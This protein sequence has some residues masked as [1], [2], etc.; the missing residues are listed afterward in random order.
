MEEQERKALCVAVIDKALDDAREF[1]GVT[2]ELHLYVKYDR[3]PE[4]TGPEGAAAGIGINL[5]YLRMEI[6]FDLTKDDRPK[7]WWSYAAHEIAHTVTRE[8]NYPTEFTLEND[9]NLFEVAQEN[10]TV[11]LERLFVRERPYPGDASFTVT[12]EHREFAGCTPTADTEAPAEAVA[13]P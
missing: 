12:D 5:V 11:R 10:A 4:A 7:N 3:P 9:R 2:H 13:V 1:F 8:F 6:W